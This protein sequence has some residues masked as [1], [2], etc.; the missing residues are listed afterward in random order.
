MDTYIPLAFDAGSRSIRFGF[1]NDRTPSSDVPAVVG[2]MLNGTE[3][4][5]H[6]NR[7]GKNLKY[8]VD[9]NTLCVPRE[10]KRFK[11]NP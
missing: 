6:T 11:T 9:T 2:D 4:V 1:C 10:G 8:K 3:S 5:V 7:I